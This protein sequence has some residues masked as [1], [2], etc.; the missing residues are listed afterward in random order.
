MRPTRGDGTVVT[1]R[2]RQFDVRPPL[3]VRAAGLVGALPYLLYVVL[4]DRSALWLWV[5]AGGFLAYIVAVAVWERRHR[6]LPRRRRS[7]WPESSPP[8]Q[9]PD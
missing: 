5:A 7:A 1:R 2:D 9:R 8:A 3:W 4:R 6:V